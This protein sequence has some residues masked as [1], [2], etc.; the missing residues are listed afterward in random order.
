MRLNPFSPK[1]DAALVQATLRNEPGA[2]DT[3]I[4]RYEQRA[5]AITLALGVDRQRAGDVVQEAFFRGIRGLKDLRDPDLFGHWF[6]S[7]VRN[8][9][10]TSLG[11]GRDQQ[12]TP[13]LER[14]GRAESDPLER[15]E[16]A[17]ILRGKVRELPEGVRE[18]VY[19]YYYEGESVK[20]VADILQ[21]TRPAVKNRLQK[22]RDLL[23]EKLWREMGETIR[24]MIPSSRKR[25]LAARQ[26][27]LAVAALLPSAWP[28]E[29]GA[30]SHVGPSSTAQKPGFGGIGASGL[31]LTLVLST[32]VVWAGLTILGTGGDDVGQGGVG[33]GPTL[34]VAGRSGIGAGNE[35]QPMEIPVDEGAEESVESVDDRGVPAAR[36]ARLGSTVTVQVE[37]STTSRGIPDVEIRIVRAGPSEGTVVGYTEDDG[38]WTSPPLPLGKHQIQVGREGYMRVQGIEEEGLLVEVREGLSSEVVI[39]LEPTSG[40]RGVLT[41]PTGT[42][43]PGI[44]VRAAGGWMGK[45]RREFRATRLGLP[46]V[47][48]GPIVTGSDGAF[49]FADL[50]GN[51]EYRLII[52]GALR[53]SK[54][55]LGITLAPG[56]IF[57]ISLELD[58]GCAIFGRVI[59]EG[60]EPVQDIPLTVN[61]AVV[62]DAGGW[63][64]LKG[65]SLRLSGE[66]EPQSGPQRRTPGKEAF[67]KEKTVR[68][69]EQGRFRFSGLLPGKK[70]LSVEY[71]RAGCGDPGSTE[72]GNVG[73][74]EEKDAGSIVLLAG[75]PTLAGSVL[76]P[77]GIA[78][79]GATVLASLR[80]REEGRGA[81]RAKTGPD[82]S[83]ALWIGRQ[84]GEYHLR[85]LPPG[86]YADVSVDR[87]I[88]ESFPFEWNVV[89][90]L[91]PPR[92][93]RGR[94][95]FSLRLPSEPEV[96]EGTGAIVGLSI[97]SADGRALKD[98]SGSWPDQFLLTMH[99]QLDAGEY[100][101]E[102]YL[103]G[104]PD[105]DRFGRSLPFR[106][107]E[108]EETEV[109]VEILHPAGTV[110][111]TF[112]DAQTNEPKQ[113][114]VVKRFIGEIDE[115]G[116][117]IHYGSAQRT[118][119][120]P[121]GRFKLR[122][123][124]TDRPVRVILQYVGTHR[125]ILRE[126]TAPADLG[127]VDP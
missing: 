35:T 63:V 37:D 119:P 2:L 1:S 106:I 75:E 87:Q 90:E 28:A 82:G 126:V 5:L 93:P 65:H 6:L 12:W 17:L 98:Y 112:R 46:L 66:S 8:T 39:P 50:L 52:R 19:L 105:G 24:E 11:K 116:E 71:N 38:S 31:A 104:G 54:T 48:P 79:E 100:K 99:W 61:H 74:G 42:P 9:A 114:A 56:E 47:S 80:S 60:G 102:A 23:R 89:P 110:T 107:K 58:Q 83:F 18:A 57:D 86:P 125:R 41:D 127:V 103:I 118:S 51:G 67:K 10:R 33:E 53:V 109:S 77:D 95:K 85:A 22:G 14:P 94:A 68:T 101:V 62:A 3:L 120:G 88:I 49:E 73:E 16:L 84:P 124:P 97:F 115:S 20:A 123:L 111:G 43:I 64:R 27:A 72:I 34:E 21:V 13:E 91:E 76:S 81:G 40:I 108:G 117:V 4:Y 92:A 70:R 55:V 113:G 29:G 121:D 96:Y 7:I 44:T 30:A 69:D 59:L 25:R 26:L 45:R 78:I 32:A 36:N 15:D 122:G